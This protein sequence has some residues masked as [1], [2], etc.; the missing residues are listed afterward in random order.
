[1]SVRLPFFV[2]TLL[3]YPGGTRGRYKMADE[4]GLK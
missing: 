4:K 2:A 1:V 3:S